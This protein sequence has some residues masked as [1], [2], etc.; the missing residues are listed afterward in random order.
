M[1]IFGVDYSWG[2]PDPAA[3]KEK[4][5]AFVCRYLSHDTTGKNLTRDEAAKLSAA[6][7]AL[8]VVWETTARRA[9]SG[10]AGGVADA[11]HAARQAGEA[12][13][14]DG[15]PIYFA[16]DFDA[17]PHHQ[18]TVDAYLD[19]AAEVLGRDRVGVYAGYGP[20]KRVLDAGKA[21]WAWQTHAWSGGK[22]D[23][24]AHIQQYSNG[25]EIDG[26]AVD[27]DRATRDDYGQ[28]R[29]ED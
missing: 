29:L 18:E 9:L 10:R 27:H 15:R 24:R 25:H 7:I 28:W 11:R 21:A 14:P 19:G 2:R 4:D 20:A 3:L 26:V 16:V 23:E 17:Q 5:V 12:G 13:M 1:T 8:V 22:W 6:G